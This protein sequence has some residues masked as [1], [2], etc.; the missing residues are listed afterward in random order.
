MNLAVPAIIGWLPEIE[1]RIMNK[2][3]AGL[4]RTS[5]LRRFGYERAVAATITSSRVE[6]I[7]IQCKR[8]LS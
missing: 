5:A 6:E 8:G 3:L 7:V 1:L 4:F 2:Y